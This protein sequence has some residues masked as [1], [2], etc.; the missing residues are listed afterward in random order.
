MKNDEWLI[1]YEKMIDGKK[2][3]VTILGKIIDEDEGTFVFQEDG[4]SFVVLKRDVLKLI[5]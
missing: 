2:K 5:G 4:E 3:I 1:T